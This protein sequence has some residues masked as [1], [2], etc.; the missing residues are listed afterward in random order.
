MVK[1]TL[2]YNIAMLNC[3]LAIAQTAPKDSANDKLKVIRSEYTII[4]SETLKCTTEDIED[5]STEG[6][7]VKKCYK[8]KE[9]RKLTAAFYGEMG[10][11]IE[12]YYFK[13]GELIFLFEK[14]TYYTAP[15]YNSSNFKIKS[16]VESR[17]YFDGGVLFKWIVG[18]TIKNKAPYR[19]KQKEI[20]EELKS[21][22]VKFKL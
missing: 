14:R 9:L 20:A 7:E 4:N 2:L 3:L 11:T 12:E 18:N 10:K 6:G 1:R 21:L 15:I 5:Q 17:Y 13:N 16:I 22:G 8:G 19:S